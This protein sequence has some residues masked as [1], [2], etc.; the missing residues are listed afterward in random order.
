LAGGQATLILGE[1]GGLASP[2][3]IF[4]PI[5]GAEL[6]AGI[7]R[8]LVIPLDREFEHALV[9]LEGECEL[10]GQPLAIDTL[11]YLGTG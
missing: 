9:L 10:E 5:V 11:Y 1:L 4:S 8:Q 6:A 2:A 3:R 7:D